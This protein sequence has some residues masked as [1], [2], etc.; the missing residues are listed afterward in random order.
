MFFVTNHF[1]INSQFPMVYVRGVLSPILFTIYEHLLELEIAGVGCY[2]KH[3]FAGAVCYADD[4]ALLAFSPSA[5]CIMPNTC[6]HFS[7]IV[8]NAHTF[9]QHAMFKRTGR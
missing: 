4:I 3:H 7:T 9:K 2:W 5:L 1:P 6:I 8:F